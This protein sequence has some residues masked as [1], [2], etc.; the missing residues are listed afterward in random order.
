MKIAQQITAVD[1]YDAHRA[2]GKARA[3]RERILDH[4]KAHG[5]DWSIGE[6]A[7]ALRMEKSTAS[8]RLNELLY[9]SGELVDKCR[10][11]DRVSGITVR[12]VGLPALGQR[13]LFQ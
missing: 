11:R 4:I 6:I 10:R 7:H 1:A 8:A 2:C 5:G 13:E 12:A 3:Q 9:D